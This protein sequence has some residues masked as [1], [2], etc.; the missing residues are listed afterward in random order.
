MDKTQMDREVAR[1][2]APIGI[3]AGLSIFFFG[4]MSWESK[5]M[6]GGQ[7]MREGEIDV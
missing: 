3:T 4:I 6:E 2:C 7:E 5:G 1:F